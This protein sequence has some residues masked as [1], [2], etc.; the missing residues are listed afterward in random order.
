VSAIDYLPII[1]GTVV[2][3]AALAALLLIPVSRFIT[4]E[5][6]RGDAWNAEIDRQKAA[7][8]T[9]RTREDAGDRAS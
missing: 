9:P 7:P 1:I 3:F 8:P 4:R 2:G 6:E 5:R